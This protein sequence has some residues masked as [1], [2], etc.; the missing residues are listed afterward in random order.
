MKIHQLLAGLCVAITNEEQ[1]FVKSNADKILLS[2]L[3]EHNTWI[4]RNL[5]RKG[6]YKLSNDNNY[7]IINRANENTN[8]DL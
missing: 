2:A 5:V 1:T 7:L 6:I 4:A 8:P 3:D